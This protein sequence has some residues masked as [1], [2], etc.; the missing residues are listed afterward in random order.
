[1]APESP[2]KIARFEVV[3]PDGAH[4]PSM[5]LSGERFGEPMRDLGA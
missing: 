1:M 2:G 4:A 3:R 5:L